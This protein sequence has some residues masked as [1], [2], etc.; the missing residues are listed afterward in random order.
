MSPV[1]CAVLACVLATGCGAEDGSLVLGYYSRS[2]L[3]IRYYLSTY[4]D[5]AT[6]HLDGD[7]VQDSRGRWT[8]ED[9]P[10]YALQ[11][12]AAE[13]LNAGIVE[14]A[15]RHWF[16][17]DLGGAGSLDPCTTR[18]AVVDLEH[19]VDFF[20]ARD[21]LRPGSPAEDLFDFVEEGYRRILVEGEVIENAHLVGQEPWLSAMPPWD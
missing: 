18:Q 14:R 9:G 11:G 2:Y 19:A 5:S 4:E 7:C 12:A 3:P 10:V 17:P 20:A 16:P 1:H 13:A 6:V 15:R 21:R 8:I